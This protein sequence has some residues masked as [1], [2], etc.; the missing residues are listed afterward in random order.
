M[1]GV[2]PH[3]TRR[4]ALTAMRWMSLGTSGPEVA[5]KMFSGCTSRIRK[6][7]VLDAST[8]RMRCGVTRKWG[9]VSC[10]TRPDT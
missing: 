5:V 4:I 8:G 3:S 7:P 6:F 9:D 10:D 1:R 2:N